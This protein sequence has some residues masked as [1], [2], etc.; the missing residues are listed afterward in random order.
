MGKAYKTLLFCSRP[1]LPA[2]ESAGVGEPL[3][4]HYCLLQGDKHC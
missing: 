4:L 2:V 1:L 3:T